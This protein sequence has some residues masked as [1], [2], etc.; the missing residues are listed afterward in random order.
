MGLEE[1]IMPEYIDRDYV[2]KLLRPR[3]KDSHKGQCGR[4]LVIAGSKGMVGAAL[5]TAKAALRSGAGLVKISL[6]EEFFPIAQVGVAEAICIDRRL[7]L[8]DLNEFD[9]IALGPGLGLGGENK[10]LVEMVLNTEKPL[11]LVD[12]DGLTSLK[13]LGDKRVRNSKKAQEGK[14]IITPHPGEAGRLLD[15]SPLEINK[16]RPLSG[17]TLSE[18]YGAISLLKGDES[19][20][21]DISGRQYINTSGNPGMAT[22]GSGDV[23][24]GII[25]ALAGQG[26]SPLEATLMGT[27]I[28]G[29]AGDKGA[30]LLGQYGLIASD[31]GSMLGLVIKEL[32]NES[33]SK[34]DI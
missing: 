10:D 19:L 25:P 13:F 8:Q 21:T 24:A 1:I 7:S 4:V 33:N 2:R 29:A 26:Y 17:K 27:Y 11:V 18:K 32:I 28:H 3:P 34:L 23:L 20:V 16:N 22:A 5:L 12:A 15:T 14:L 31:I 6:D 30:D 9:S